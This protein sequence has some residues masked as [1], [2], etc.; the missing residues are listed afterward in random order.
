M[1]RLLLI[2]FYV[3]VMAFVSLAILISGIVTGV[4][5]LIRWV[6]T[7]TISEIENKYLRRATFCVMAALWLSVAVVSV[8]IA[9]FN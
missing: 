9:F 8:S 7:L 4:R 1:T 3:L 5:D 2:P 6:E